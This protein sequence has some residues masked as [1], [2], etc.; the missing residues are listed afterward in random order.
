M[1]WVN[2]FRQRAGLG[3]VDQLMAL[4]DASAAHSKYVLVNPD[5]YDELGLSVHE[6]LEGREAFFGK[7]FWDR[8]KRAGYDGDAFREVIAYQAHPAAAVAHWMETVYHRLPLLHPSARHLGYA[9]AHLGDARINVL[10]IGSGNGATPTIPGGVV[11]PP[12]GATNVPTSWDGLE[13]PQPAAPP[14]GYPSGPVVTLTFGLDSE[15]EIL[16]HSIR[17]YGQEEEVP[18]VFL[19][20][21]NDPNLEGESSIALYAHTPL[22]SGVTYEVRVKGVVDG[23]PFERRWTFATRPNDG[24]NLLAQDCGVGKACY[25]TSDQEAVCAW[26]GAQFEGTTCGYQNDCSAGFTCVASVCRAYCRI[27]SGSFRSCE[28]ICPNGFT[29]INNDSALGA[30]I[31]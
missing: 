3:P 26:S 18:H 17:R 5:V 2:T 30:C 21:A 22:G 31:P 8:M 16:D 24:C 10:D 27:T 15:F 14:A 20:P 7:R 23:A 1:W 4:N 28:D 12:D 29:A 13:S 11:W 9:E 19:S 6:E 25:G